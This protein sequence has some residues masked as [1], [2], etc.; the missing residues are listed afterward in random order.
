MYN[1]A[2]VDIFLEFTSVLHYPN[3]AGNLVSGSTAFS[4]SKFYIC[5]FSVYVQLKLNLKN[6]EHNL[7]DMCNECNCTVI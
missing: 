7:T 4:K 6:F 3:N 2:E 1:E 5:N